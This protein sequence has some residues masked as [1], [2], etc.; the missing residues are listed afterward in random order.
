MG[1]NDSQY[2]GDC[3]NVATVP[4]PECNELIEQ[5]VEGYG[6][7]ILLCECGNELKLDL[8]RFIRKKSADYKDKDWLLKRY[9]DEE[10]SMA[11]IASICAV[12]PMTIHNWLIT[13]DIEKRSRGRRSK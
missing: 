6:V 9:V 1:L 11:E 5:D 13:H 8:S 2:V 10:M 7:H 4:C 3:M 12:S